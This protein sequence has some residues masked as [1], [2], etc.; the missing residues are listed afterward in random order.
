[1]A[2]YR[3]AEL[4][5]ELIL[6]LQ[7]SHAELSLEDVR[8][9]FGVSR[10]TAERM[11][12]AVRG[13]FPEF[14][15]QEDGSLIVRYRAGGLQEMAKRLALRSRRRSSGSSNAPRPST[16]RRRTPS[17]APSLNEPPGDQSCGGGCG[18]DPGTTARSGISDLREPS[19]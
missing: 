17:V 19:S 6:E 10:R 18:P 16:S 14:E 9:R 8:E 1:M 7:G 12:D 11:C 13:L 5:I 3:Q 2:R 15:D 4:L